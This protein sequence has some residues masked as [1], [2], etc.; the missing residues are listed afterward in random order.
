V[1]FGSFNNFTKLNHAVTNAWIAILER[2][3]G[4][5]LLLSG[6]PQGNARMAFAARFAERGI[7]ASRIEFVDRLPLTAFRALHGRVDIAL[8]PFPFAGG[9]TTCESL[10]MGVPVVTLA[11][12]FGFARTGVSLLHG[13]GLESL[14]AE[15]VDEYVEIARRTAADPQIL[16]QLR[17]TL[18]ERILGGGLC[19]GPR[20][21]AKLEAAY[22]GMWRVRCGV[23]YARPSIALPGG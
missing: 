2:C 3:A 12:A 16:R 13:I 7:E 19:D 21:A 14:V 6:A 18:R 10:W 8:D 23:A 17:D 22:R 9:A 11:G 1:T 15:D 4:S 5:R 20:F